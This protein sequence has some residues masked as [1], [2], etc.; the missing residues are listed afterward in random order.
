VAASKPS[1]ETE[2]VPPV[3]L[4]PLPSGGGVVHRVGGHLPYNK[5]EKSK[6]CQ[7][8]KS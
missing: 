1:N 8:T 3:I 6:S 5:P 7:R 4:G 2:S